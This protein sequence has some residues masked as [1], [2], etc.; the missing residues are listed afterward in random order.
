[1]IMNQLG[2]HGKASIYPTGRRNKKGEAVYGIS[3][4]YNDI[5]G[6]RQ[7]KVITG[8]KEELLQ[9]RINFLNSIYLQKLEALNIAETT[10]AANPS[11]TA[12]LSPACTVTLKRAIEEFLIQYEPT[13]SHSTF[14]GEKTNTNNITRIMGDML[15]KDITFD[16]FQSLVNTISQGKNGNQAAPKTV[17][18]HII[19]FKR[20][21]K[22][23]RKKKWISADDLELITSDIKI[24][25]YI[26]DNDHEEEV[27][28]EKALSCEEAKKVL[29]S[30]K[31]NTRYY[32]VAKILLLTGMRPQEFF[33]LEKSDLVKKEGYIH[34]RQA[35]IRQNTKIGNNRLYGIGTTKN[36]G[37]RRKVPATPL[38][39]HYFDELE[40]LMMKDGSRKKSIA[41]GNETMVIV[42]KNGN[43][44]DEHAFGINMVRYLQRNGNCKKF[45]LGM[46][47]HFYQ[48]QLDILGANIN[49]VEKA[50]GHVIN[51]VSERHY[52][53]NEQYLK[54]LLPYVEDLGVMLENPEKCCKNGLDFD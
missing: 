6:C 47:R 10:T 50:V 11:V 42:D 2:E 13:V 8:N 20:I 36:K 17:R 23:C 41:M 16:D 40:S 7:R 31:K 53:V 26:T 9:K 43:I 48:D 38:L 28:E 12:S 4:Y 35:L 24:P 37:S 44:I 33:A 14:L 5:K 30:L 3:F 27:K 29:E 22:Y 25:T 52:K 54:R 39:F 19:S 32:L 49:D 34:I 45:T 21:M 15:I 51:T 1:M 18:N 46:P